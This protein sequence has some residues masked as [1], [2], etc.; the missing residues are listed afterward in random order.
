MTLKATLNTTLANLSEGR[1]VTFAQ[2]LDPAWIEQALQLTG[3][4]SVRRRK[5]PA[6]RVVWLVLGMALLRDHSIQAV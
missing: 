5:L 4:A 3:R 1:Q 6:D 2:H